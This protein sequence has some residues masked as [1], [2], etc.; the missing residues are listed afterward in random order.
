VARV[1]HYRTLPEAPSTSAVEI[2]TLPLSSPTLLSVG[3]AVKLPP[4]SGG[5]ITPR[6]R[7]P[8]QLDAIGTK[9]QGPANFVQRFDYAEIGIKKHAQ[10]FQGR[11]A[12]AFITSVVVQW[13]RGVRPCIGSNSATCIS[14]CLVVKSGDVLRVVRKQ[15]LSLTAAEL[16]TRDKAR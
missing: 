13:G 11:D 9:N 16:P 1:D 10:A 14:C 6:Q 15:D 5:L 12:D 7:P 8:L 2:P 3:G 4:T